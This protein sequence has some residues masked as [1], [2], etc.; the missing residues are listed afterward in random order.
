MAADKYLLNHYSGA[1]FNF[2]IGKL[3]N[4]N[5]CLIYEQLVRIGDREESALAYVRGRIIENSQEAIESEH[6]TQINQETLISLL[7]LEKLSIDEIDLFKAV[8]KWID[9]EAQRRGLPVNRENRRLV[10]EPIKGY[11]RFSALTPEEVANCKE[12]VELLTEE[13]LLPLL[14]HLL[15]KTDYPLKIQQITPR[16][17][18]WSSSFTRSSVLSIV[19]GI[20]RPR[21]RSFLSYSLFNADLE[22]L[23]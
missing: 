7:S 14:L 6:F 23:P 9:C 20:K 4:E 21:R 19:R 10:F 17:S 5:S 3:T 16:K 22:S 13:E 15:N 1:F 8:S 18:G 2:I 12:V 11:I